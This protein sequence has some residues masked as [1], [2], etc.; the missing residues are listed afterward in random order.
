MTRWLLIDAATH[1]VVSGPHDE[2]PAPRDGEYAAIVMAGWPDTATWSPELGGFV[3]PPAPP[4]LT[5]LAFQRLFT[6][7][8]RIAIRTSPDPIVQ[9]FMALAALALDI[10]LSDADVMMGVGYLETLGLIGPGR[11]AAVLAGPTRI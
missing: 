5:P 1:E 6:Q 4:T 2:E 8:E 11:A 9:D 10:D 7:A 3:R